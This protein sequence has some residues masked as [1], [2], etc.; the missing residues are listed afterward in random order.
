MALPP[1][2]SEEAGLTSYAIVGG[3]A[4]AVPVDLLIPGCPPTPQQILTGLRAL[5]EAN[6]G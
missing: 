4:A 6:A 3:V 1:S 2:G 5:V